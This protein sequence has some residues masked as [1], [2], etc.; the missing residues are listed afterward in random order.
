M[1]ALWSH[2][3]GEGNASCWIALGE[4]L[5]DTLDYHNKRSM[6][7]EVFLSKC[8]KMFNIFETQ[9][10]PMPEEARIRFLLKKTQ[11][12]QLQTMVASLKT[13][14]T[15]E[16]PGTIR[17]PTV[18]N[19]LAS[20]VSELPEYIQQNRTISA[21]ILAPQS[22]VTCDDGTI[23]MGFL[24][25]WRQLS[26][27]ERDKVTEER[28][29]QKQK[30]KPTGGQPSN[31]RTEL[32]NLKKK[33]SKNKRTIAALKN[34]IEKEKEVANDS[35][36]DDGSQDVDAGDGFGGTREKKSKRE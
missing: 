25:N 28:K 34:K 29:K 6:A 10:E 31:V 23:H 3:A 14:M 7:F 33:L 1:Q 24:S 13:R 15:T 8:Q 20:C 16:P 32:E 19:H 9:R 5:R 26:P 21:A 4:R 36:E 2:F 27:D 12:P 11:C 22:G 35:S 17:Y 30:R 18:S